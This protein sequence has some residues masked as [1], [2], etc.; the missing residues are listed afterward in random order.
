MSIPSYAD[1]LLTPCEHRV[2]ELVARGKNDAQIAVLIVIERQ[3]VSHHVRNV[4]Q[5]F[6]TVNR[7]VATVQYDLRYGHRATADEQQPVTKRLSTQECHVIECAAEGLSDPQIA[8]RLGV[9][10]STVRQHLLSVR[11][12][13]NAPNRTAAAVEY[14]RHVRLLAHIQM[15]GSEDVDYVLG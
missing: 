12:K 5:K 13:L 9:S 2:M 6:G 15:T 10:P 4:C 8:M 3:T 14:Y 1:E 11:R 7:T